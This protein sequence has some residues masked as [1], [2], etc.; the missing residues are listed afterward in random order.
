MRKVISDEVVEIAKKH[1]KMEERIEIYWKMMMWYIEWKMVDERMRKYLDPNRR[2]REK[3]I[4]N[5]NSH[6]TTVNRDGTTVKNSGGTTV[7]NRDGTTVK[8]K[9]KPK[10]NQISEE[11]ITI[12]ISNN[13][14]LY[15]K[16]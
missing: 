2:R 9:S 10:K 8:G 15:D 7:K 12:Y 3:M 1:E 5:D 14:V 13:N 11:A 16:R 4:G 6:G